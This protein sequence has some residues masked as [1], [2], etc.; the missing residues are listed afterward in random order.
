MLQIHTKLTT[1]GQV[2][3]PAA[4]R[5][6]L[7][8]RP[9][10]TLVWTQHDGKVTVERAVLHSSVEVHQALFA[11]DQNK[12]TKNAVKPTTKTLTQLKNGIKQRMKQRHAGN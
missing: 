12:G 1:Q 6:V 3:V 2:S 9:G 4:I 5:H 11:T 7:A 8:H 10:S